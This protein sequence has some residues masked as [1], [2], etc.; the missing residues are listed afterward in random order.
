M[1]YVAVF[2]GGGIG[3]ALR[4]GVNRAAMTWLG[5]GFPYGTL[6]VNVVGGLMMG[7]LAEMFS[8]KGGGTQEFRLFLT[9]GLLGGFTTFSAFSLESA[10]LW[11]RGEMLDLGAFMLGNVVLSIAAL[12]LGIAIVRAAS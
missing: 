8:A 4:H 5:I 9:T 6:F 1:H 2:I 10:L 12:F 3:A 7:I 11:K